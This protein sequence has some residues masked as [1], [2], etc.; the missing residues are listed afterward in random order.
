MKRFILALLL[1]LTSNQLQAAQISFE[2][3]KGT[4]RLQGLRVAYQPWSQQLS[5]FNV[6]AEYDFLQNI[7][8]SFETS[9]NLW[10]Y[11]NPSEYQNNFALALS[12]V[13]TYPI[14]QLK[15]KPVLFEFGIGVSVLNKRHF[16]GK[17][18]GSYFQFEDRLGLIWQTSE[19]SAITMR[20]MHYS[21]GGLARHN[22]GMDFFNLAYSWRW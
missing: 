17:D 13:F 22:P 3:L 5:E 20:Y 1:L 4:G 21:N 16:A 6:F 10:R 9:T 14:T 11:G 8:I 7:G 12:P 18:L 19:K 2:Y 15:G